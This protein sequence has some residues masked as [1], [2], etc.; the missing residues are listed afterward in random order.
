MPFEPK[1][2]PVAVAAAAPS[3]SPVPGGAPVAPGMPV[4]APVV[5]NTVAAAPIDYEAMYKQSQRENATLTERFGALETRFDDTAKLQA[6]VVAL[7]ATNVA[8]TAELKGFRDVEIKQANELYV[9]I[10]EERRKAI[11][12]LAK[13]MTSSTW[14]S[15]LQSEV[16][17]HASAAS[18][19]E[20]SDGFDGSDGS[21]PTIPNSGT[22]D[23]MRK[24]KQYRPKYVE[25]IEEAT[26]RDVVHLQNMQ[27]RKDAGGTNFRMNAKAFRALLMSKKE[28]GVQINATTAASRASALLQQQ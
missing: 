20:G 16:K 27:V 26:G 18:G 24:T 11:E 22:K 7:Q 19:S 23:K 3:V 1:N 25:E 14:L 17:L 8:A 28:G 6:E 15:F 12:P 2:L 10:P 9:K 5:P 4:P 13:G 21:P